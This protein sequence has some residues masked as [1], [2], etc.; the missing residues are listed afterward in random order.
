MNEATDPSRIVDLNQRLSPASERVGELLSAVRSIAGRRLQQGLG[1]TFESLMGVEENNDKTADLLGI[2]LKAKLKK[3][4]ARGEGKTNLF[5]Q[6]PEWM[7]SL[8]NKELIRK[9]GQRGENGRWSCYSA[10]TTHENNLGL[11]LAP[12]DA[13]DRIDLNKRTEQ[14]GYWPFA[15]LEKRLE[16]KHSRAVFVKAASSVRTGSTRFAYQELVYCE[17]PK[18]ENF[19]SLVKTGDI[20]FEFTMSEKE[21]GSIRNH[22]YPWRLKDQ[23]LLDRLFSFFIRLRG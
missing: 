7:L 16:E 5:Q 9:I 15:S 6:A 21:N 14:I 3:D 2:E 10:V 13:R 19:V 17:R 18:L 4:K 8:T 23:A 22:G 20:L 11:Y 12:I 1:Y